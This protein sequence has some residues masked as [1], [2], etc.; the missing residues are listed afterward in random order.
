MT[1]SHHNPGYQPALHAL[2]DQLEAAAARG[3]PSGPTSTGTRWGRVLLLPALAVFAVIALAAALLVPGS[4]KSADAAVSAAAQQTADQSTGRFSLTVSASGVT[5]M[6]DVD[7]TVEG[8]Y[9]IPNERYEVSMDLT[10]MAGVLGD[11]AGMV[12]DASVRVVVDGDVMYLHLGGMSDFL[13]LD[14]EWLRVDMADLAGAAG[15]GEAEVPADQIDPGLLAPGDVLGAL[16]QMGGEVTEVGTEEVRGV[17]TT[18]YSGQIDLQKALDEL[19]PEERDEVQG[20]LD[21]VAP[22]ST[23]PALPVDVWIDDE[24]FVR[25]VE[26]SLSLAE[27][28][29]PADAVIDGQVSVTMEFFDLGAPVDIQP[30]SPDQVSEFDDLFGGLG[31][32]MIDGFGALDELDLDG[33][34]LEGLGLDDLDLDS[35]DL[36]GLDLDGLFEGLEDFDIEGFDIEGFD[37]GDLEGELDELFGDPAET[38]DQTPGDGSQPTPAQVGAPTA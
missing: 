32:A 35:L 37:L 22:D 11:A 34:G 8:A 6:P 26:L 1:E 3:G 21:F 18:H 19:T 14:G 28:P 17:S 16:E 33:L 27:L 5:Q 10:S 20:L 38:P 13:G 4:S 29:G 24:G 30:P 25:R 15:L 9:D 23:L 36:G 12:G 7:L 2:G 31:G